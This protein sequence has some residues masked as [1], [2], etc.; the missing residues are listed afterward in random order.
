VV[1]V[2]VALAEELVA[3]GLPI[4]AM[5]EVALLQLAVVEVVVLVR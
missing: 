1:L 3:L 2:V 4:K 5:L